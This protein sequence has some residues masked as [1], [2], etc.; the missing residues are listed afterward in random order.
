MMPDQGNLSTPESKLKGVG[1]I[2]HKLGNALNNDK[3]SQTTKSNIFYELNSLV[4]NRKSKDF[5]LDLSR[6]CNY[7]GNEYLL[8][9]STE[10]KGVDPDLLK[11]IAMEI[12]NMPD[13]EIDEALLLMKK[14]CGE[15]NDL[16]VSKEP[17]FRDYYS[18][19]EEA[20]KNKQPDKALKIIN[21]MDKEVMKYRHD[22]D[23]ENVAGHLL[24]D[25][26]MLTSEL[27][28]AKEYPHGFRYESC[29]NILKSSFD[30][31]KKF[32]SIK[33]RNKVA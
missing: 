12:R 16:D 18:E 19:V 30:Y 10:E 1:Y 27:Y 20:I 13:E 17:G 25:F 28:R 3:I 7:W 15:T 26:G 6:L 31:Y 9:G 8:S 2:A 29:F 33:N 4:A 22:K 23:L 24:I 21:E 5:V 32:I 11:D 14:F